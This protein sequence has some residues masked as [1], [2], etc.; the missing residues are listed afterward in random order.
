MRKTI[1]MHLLR[2]DSVGLGH[3]ARSHQVQ[4]FFIEQPITANEIG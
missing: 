1:Y 4:E 3:R 2:T